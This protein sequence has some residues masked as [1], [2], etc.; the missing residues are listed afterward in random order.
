MDFIDKLIE[1]PINSADP[2]FNVESMLNR[3]YFN[4]VCL[5]GRLLG[6][7]SSATLDRRLRNIIDTLAFIQSYAPVDIRRIF[8][9]ING[10][11]EKM[12]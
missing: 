3:R 12:H 6:A 7:D 2:R 11:L 10:Y 5:L 8:H 9:N 4:V 1:Y